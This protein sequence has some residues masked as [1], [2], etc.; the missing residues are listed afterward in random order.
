MAKEV[1]LR[2]KEICS[3]KGL[4]L[5]ELA[6]RLGIRRTSL[7]QAMSRNSFSTSKLGEIADA[8]GVP[9]YELFVDVEDLVTSANAPDPHSL[10]CPKCGARFRLVEDE[11]KKE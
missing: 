2:I 3:E 9:V 10:T 8:L 11:V 5:E 7:A 1:H 6:K 4:T